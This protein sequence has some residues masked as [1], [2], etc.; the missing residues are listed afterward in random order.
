MIEKIAQKLSRS[1][2]RLVY[3][4]GSVEPR[5]LVRILCNLTRTCELPR[6]RTQ[7]ISYTY[8]YGG[9]KLS[10]RLHKTR[11]VGVFLIVPL[12]V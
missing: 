1:V 9:T 7:L 5:D 6:E 10:V 2:P 12:V 8:Y 4:S 3:F 11:F